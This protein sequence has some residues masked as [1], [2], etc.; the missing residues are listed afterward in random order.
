MFN[1][2]Q[3]IGDVLGD[4]NIIINGDVTADD[5]VLTKVA[6]QLLKSELDNLTIEAKAQM[7][8]WVNEAVSS[9]LDQMVSRKIETK[10]SEFSKP[11]TQFALY[12]MLKGYTASETLEQRELLVDAFI[13]RIQ[14]NWN[15]SEKMIIDSALDILPKLTPQALSTIGLL[16]L[17]HQL[18]NTS[19][20][21]MLNQYFS[22]LTPL[23][24]KMARING[25]DIDY[26]KQVQLILRLSSFNKTASLEGT[27]LKQ[28]DL[29]FRHPLKGGVFEQYCKIHP[30]A[31]EAVFDKPLG[32]CMMWIDPAHNNNASFCFANSKLFANSLK[33][34]RQEYIIPL[35]E[36]LKQMMPVFTEAEVRDYFVNLS[37]SWKKLF[38]LFSSDDFTTYTLSITG[39]YIGGKVL[40]KATHST[41]LKL[42][43]YSHNT[44][45]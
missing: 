4:H 10:I 17:R 18:V 3:H 13:E 20:S 42:T 25:L 21:F 37:P 2:I 34:R 28:Y 7:E 26:L 32:A 8:I 14:A 44:S 19:I 15:S 38:D 41:S 12:S 5:E 16:Q 45:L 36:E 23:V 9:V 1:R 35:V 33:T 43:D 6:H 40:A 31:H 29:F 27:L 11:S 30:Q 24:E 22:R 39:N